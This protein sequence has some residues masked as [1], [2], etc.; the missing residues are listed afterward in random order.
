MYQTD[1]AGGWTNPSGTQIGSGWGGFKSI[2]T[3]GGWNG[4]NMMDMLGVDSSY[5]LR[6]YTTDGKGNWIDARG[7]V[8]STGWDYF[9]LVF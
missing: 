7:K 5:R 9:N 6:M 1:L 4:D 2:V 8:I 3:P